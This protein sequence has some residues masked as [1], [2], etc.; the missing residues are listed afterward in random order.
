MATVVLRNPNWI[1]ATAS[2]EAAAAMPLGIDIGK[3]C[4]FVQREDL[5][6]VWVRVEEAT[7]AGRFWRGSK[8]STEW[9]NSNYLRRNPDA[10]RN[11]HVICV[12]THNFHDVADVMRVREE[13]HK[14]GVSQALGYKTDADTA[15]GIERWTYADEGWAR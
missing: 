4:V 1:Y 7:N 5:E 6:D 8:V 14:I 2:A 12:Y 3:W 10:D 9:A 13:L 15:K 11:E